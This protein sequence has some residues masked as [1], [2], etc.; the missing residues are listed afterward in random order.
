MKTHIE[1]TDVANAH[2][3]YVVPTKGMH[4]RCVRREGERA[5]TYVSWPGV[6]NETLMVR[7]NSRTI[8]SEVNGN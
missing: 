1:L 5:V 4:V 6:N 3:V 8:L 2:T 7:E